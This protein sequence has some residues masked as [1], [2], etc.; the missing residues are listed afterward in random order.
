MGKHI[1]FIGLGIMGSSMAGN[2]LAKGFKLSVFNR[3]VEKAI[4]LVQR[5][6]SHAASAAQ[7]ARDCDVVLLNLSD[8]PVIKEL[9][10]GSA[11]VADALRP[12]AV[13]VIFST[14][15]PKEAIQIADALQRK[16]IHCLDAPV[17]GGDIGA[18][19]ATL[20]IMVGGERRCF[21]ELQDIFAAVGKKIAYMGAAG[22][23]QM[24]KAINQIAV[25]LS[26]AAMTESLVLAQG[27]GLEV[28]Q[29]LDILQSGAAGSWSM[30]NYAPRILSG[31]L[32]PGFFAKHM[33]KD[34]KIVLDE[35]RALGISLPATNL[36][37]ELYQSLVDG[38]G[39]ELGN[40]ALI[41]LY[42]RHC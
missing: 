15:A 37:K 40:H 19:N 20:T 14:I 33:L 5:G 7:C 4:P 16:G 42:A 13:V 24:M 28:P 25:A 21:D 1:G 41:E 8:G 35:S 6:A 26:V 30:S 34:L 9:L 3:S 17:S 32:K 31:D 18:K 23:G 36:M 29:A 10:F 12:D 27:A 2:L 38:P 39:A 22:S 11:N